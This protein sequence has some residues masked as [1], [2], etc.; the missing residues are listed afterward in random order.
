[1]KEKEEEDSRTEREYGR[2]GEDKRERGRKKKWM[3]KEK[4]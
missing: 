2:E 3:R 1:L 4:R